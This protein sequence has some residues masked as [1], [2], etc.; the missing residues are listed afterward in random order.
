MHGND[1]SIHEN[2]KCAS[3]IFDDLNLM[4]ENIGGKI[5]IFIHEN[6]FMHESFLTVIDLPLY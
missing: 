5:L 4:H 2:K 1:I 6:I 3:T